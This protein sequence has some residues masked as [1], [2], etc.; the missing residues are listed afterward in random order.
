M[1]ASPVRMSPTAVISPPVP[2][3]EMVK[4]LVLLSVVR[5]TPEPA[6]MF[7]AVVVESAVIVVSVGTTMEEK[8][9]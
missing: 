8:R 7:K 4:V 2:V 1:K 6:S 5:E 9:F 3:A